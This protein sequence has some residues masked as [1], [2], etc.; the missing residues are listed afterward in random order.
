MHISEAM[1]LRMGRED[2]GLLK[3]YMV[4]NLSIDYIS[5]KNKKKTNLDINEFY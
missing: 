4:V 1:K 5:V 2:L 3:T